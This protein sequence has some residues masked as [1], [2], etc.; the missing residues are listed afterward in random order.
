MSFE[1]LMPWLNTSLALVFLYLFLTGKLISRSVVDELIQAAITEAVEVA[2]KVAADA[3]RDVA[4]ET[5]V[6]QSET[7]N[8]AV[9]E[10]ASRTVRAV[11]TMSE[12]QRG[13]LEAVERRMVD[14]AVGQRTA[15]RD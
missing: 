10:M 3:L 6:E 1:S 5:F 9:A 13:L 11:N 15:V 14:V 8:A 4:R 12:E 2:I 7:I